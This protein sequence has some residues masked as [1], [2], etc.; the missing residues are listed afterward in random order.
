[1]KSA[2]IDVAFG[3]MDIDGLYYLN[4]MTACS[5]I[6]SHTDV[7]VHLH[8]L[9]DET[10][11]TS[12][13]EEF[14][15]FVIRN[16]HEISFYDVSKEPKLNQ[17]GN[18]SMYKGMLYRLCMFDYCLN[19]DKMI[20]LD[21]DV[22]VTGDINELW[23]VDISNYCLGVVKDRPYTREM[24]INNAYYR[25]IG[26]APELYFNSGV[27]LINL[28]KIRENID[29]LS[30]LDKFAIKYP[31][32]AM[33]DQDFLNY[34]F[35][36]KVLYLSPIYNFIPENVE[37]LTEK[38]LDTNVIIHLAGTFKPWNCRNP[39]VIEYFCDNFAKVLKKEKQQE[40]IIKYMSM[41]PKR[42]FE[43]MGLRYALLQ[44]D[45]STLK[46]NK[47]IIICTCFMKGILSDKIFRL[48]AYKF[49]VKFKLKILYSF[50][51]CL[52]L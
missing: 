21:G 49:M 47:F 42:H 12:H 17:A 44:Y 51:Y 15:N 13:I 31:H 23:K 10:L 22:L 30:E 24:Y 36:N 6:F 16:E 39:I 27:L 40:Y 29:V 45:K 26:L 11:S 52:D 5:E 1:M 2:K 50:Y 35:K 3:V 33:L 43:K 46:E 8:I 37:S 25:K 32:C 18:V 7:K 28:S 20:Y 14:R 4:I 34:A 48:L 9:H 38:D 19:V 41:L